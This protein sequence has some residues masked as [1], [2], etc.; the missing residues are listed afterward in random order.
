MEALNFYLKKKKISLEKSLFNIKGIGK[1][2]SDFRFY[3]D[4]GDLIFSSKNTFEIINKKEFSRK[5]QL[6]LKSLNNIN[7]ILFKL[8]KNIDNGEISISNIYLNK[9]DKEHS[10]EEYYIIKNFQL[11]KSFIRSI[12]S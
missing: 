12:L 6:S 8:E 4:K 7:R 9:I 10:S 1:L 5:F 11:L 3:E 2:S